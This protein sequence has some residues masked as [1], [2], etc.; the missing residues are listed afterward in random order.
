VISGHQDNGTNV[1]VGNAY[2]SGIGGDGMDCFIDRTN[3]NNMFG[4]LYYGDFERS[5]DGGNSF[6]SITN[7]TPGNGDWVTPWEQ[8]PVLPNVLYA[9]FDQLYKTTNQGNSWAPVGTQGFGNL[10]DIEIAP[11]NTQRI[12]VSTDYQMFR[13]DDGGVTWTNVSAGLNNSGGAIT[14]IAASSYDHNKVWATLS[15]YQANEKIYYSAN[16]GTTW[17]NI[18]YGLPNLP[19]NCVV[20][21]PGSSSDAI[22]VGC[23]V[24]VYYRDNA[25]ATWVPFFT[26]LPH[27]PVSD[28]DIF[29]PT[30][31]LTAA[32]YGRGVWE[33]PIDQ[34]LLAPLADFSVSQQTI[35]AGQTVA[36]TDLSTLA[37]TAW[38]WSFP[39][40][41]PAVSSQQN[42]SV[43]YST[44]GIYPVTLV[45]TNA[46][47]S[48]T[49][50]RTTYITVNSAQLPPY[51]EGFAST[52]FL[53]V[54]WT[55]VNV[56]NQAHYWQR[57]ATVGHNSS[58]SAFFNNYNNNVAGYRDEMRSTGLNF[59]G[60]TSLSLTFDVAYARY[61][62]TR[63]DTLE[64]LV[65]ADCGATWTQV[66]IKGGNTLGT[67]S[68]QTSAF[69]PTNSQWRTETVNINSY[70][71]QPSVIVAFSNHG[72]N[73]NY[74]WIDNINITGT[75]NAAPVSA[76]SA[77]ASVCENNTRTF[78]DLSAPAATSWS[79]T[80]PGGTPAT[81]TSQNPSVTWSAPGTY[82]VSLVSANSFGSDSSSQVITVLA[83]PSA[84]AG[85]DTTFC[86]GTYVQLGA[87]GGVTYSWSPTTG[88]SNT[89][90]SSPGVYLTSSRTFSVTVTDINGCSAMDT[91]RVDILPNP[92]FNVAS[93]PNSV[94]YGDTALVTATNPNW[95]YTWTPASTLSVA[96]GDTVL[97]WPN[98]ST[99]YTV[100]ATDTNGC[101]GTMTR[102]VN[103]YPVMALPVVLV[104]GWNLTCSTPGFTYQ[105]YLNGS[106]IAGATS[107]TYVATQ[108]GNYSV[109]AIS[110]AGCESGISPQEFVNGVELPDLLPF[111]IAPNPN[112]GAF[113]LSFD[114]ATGADFTI[115]IYSVDGKLVYIEELPRFS[116]RY[117][118]RIDLSGFGNGAYF[119]RLTNDKQESTQRVI[120]F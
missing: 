41:T 29:L 73:G 22:F 7:G 4:E 111:T 59:S 88:I 78:T 38:S 79:W 115:T 51:V 85:A 19:A 61:N 96:T 58:E 47:G 54:G 109:E 65:S 5:T 71:G 35:C 20:A 33:C 15:G 107:Q 3:D 113:D 77:G 100:T 95:S 91:V 90:I 76:F 53:P 74:L 44:P 108:V 18:S 9:G 101:S 36:F 86:S 72:R 39:G 62:S 57:S 42:P 102:A 30:M 25:S 17:T 118:K 117:S 75:V 82:T 50:T 14:R 83:A 32:T 92:T 116:G 10:K 80:F 120:V 60:Y 49:T 99:T 45:A 34:S 63:S 93:S 89:T 104:N 70:A 46:A 1:K 43:T 26:G 24:G 81:S 84:D 56:Q 8:D 69:T 103:V 37:P 31:T 13:S 66:Y 12:Y 68:S 110:G 87:S 119:I 94:C 112:N 105:W 27:A 11:S 114:A 2:F 98:V 28:L 55:A 97:A 67:V 40:G 6:N 21:V 48:G 16:G 106:P 52:T 64:V 23:D